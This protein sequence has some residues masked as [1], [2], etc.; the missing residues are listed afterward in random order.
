MTIHDQTKIDFDLLKEPDCLFLSDAFNEYFYPETGKDAILVLKAVGCNVRLLKTIGAGRTL[1]SKGFLTP[2]KKHAQ[3]LVDEI[4]NIDPDGKYPVIGL[5]PSEIYTL[6]DEYL[7]LLPGSDYV[8]NLAQRVYMI[9]EFLLRPSLDGNPRIS[10]LNSAINYQNN[11]TDVLLHGHCYKKAQPLASDGLPIG[12]VA[13][14]AMLKAVGYSVSI[15]DDGCCGMAGAFGYEAE[16][17]ELSMKVGNLSLFPAVNEARNSVLAAPGVSCK[18][19]MEDGT[20]REVFHPITLV[21]RRWGDNLEG[22]K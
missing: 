7:D 2:A 17:Y 1:I 18:S 5:E 8:K 20:G 4:I 15:I 12:V 13:T 21:A 10:G 9:D 16:H 22:E 14:S 6:K 3:R 11:R 19:Q